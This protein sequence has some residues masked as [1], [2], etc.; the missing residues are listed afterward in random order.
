MSSELC[1]SSQ[2]YIFQQPSL[3]KPIPVLV[4]VTNR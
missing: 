3:K 4:L 2:T 1:L